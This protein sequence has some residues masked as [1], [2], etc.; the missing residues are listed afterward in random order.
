MSTVIE[1]PGISPKWLKRMKTWH[2]ARSDW[3][4]SSSLVDS[5]LEYYV[6]SGITRFCGLENPDHRSKGAHMSWTRYLHRS[7]ADY[8]WLREFEFE[9]LATSGGGGDIALAERSFAA[10]YLKEMIGFY[11]GSCDFKD[12]PFSALGII[13]GCKE[14]AF[15]I[16]RLRLAYFRVT[17]PSGM[18][19]NPAEQYPIFHFML[20]LIADYLNE[21]PHL[22]G[23]TAQEE[24]IFRE[25]FALWREPDPAALVHA[26]LAACDFHTHRCWKNYEEHEYFSDY[27]MYNPIEILL[28]FRLRQYLGLQNP[29]LDHPIMNTPLGV[30]PEEMSCE[31]DDLIRRVRERME[32]NGFDEAKVIALFYPDGNIPPAP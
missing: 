24:P 19:P 27:L 4:D 10:F 17:I 15:R 9:S 11:T 6:E 32:E 30:L 16:A 13:L 1:R 25:L 21:P 20:R 18:I 12:T 22:L 5:D 23:G 7:L 28:L 26:C 2:R 31:P 29:I 8:A 14:K 3:H